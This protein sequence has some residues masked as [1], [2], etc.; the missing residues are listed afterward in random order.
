MPLMRGF[1][2]VGEAG[3]LQV[4]VNLR[5]QMG[6][7]PGEPFVVDVVRINGTHRRPRMFLHHRGMTPFISLRETLFARGAG[8]IAP[9][10]SLTL[11]RE[12]VE[13]VGLTP[14]SLL[15]LKIMGAANAPWA[16]VHNRGVRRNTTLQERLGTSRR[17]GKQRDTFVLDY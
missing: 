8:K 2:K 1:A 13:E 11:P 12:I 16:V 10:G 7:L 9:D 6:L 17:H 15:E 4:P 14:G 5:R 3:R